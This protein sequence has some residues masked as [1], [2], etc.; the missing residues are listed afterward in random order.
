MKH[1]EMCDLKWEIANVCTILIC[2][3]SVFFFNN[4]F[5]TSSPLYILY[6]IHSYYDLLYITSVYVLFVQHFDHWMLQ[7]HCDGNEIDLL[8]LLFAICVSVAA[9]CGRCIL[10]SR[11]FVERSAFKQYKCNIYFLLISEQN[12]KKNYSHTTVVVN[13]SKQQSFDADQ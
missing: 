5:S 7:L 13:K 6:L 4:D 12:K 9:V 10:P 1:S 2:C 11:V 8:R 3:Y